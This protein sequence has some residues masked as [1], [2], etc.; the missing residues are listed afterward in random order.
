[1]S[2]RS[3]IAVLDGRDE[4]DTRSV[5]PRTDNSIL[6]LNSTQAAPSRP[7][8]FQQPYQLL[9]FSYTSLPS[10]QDAS[11]RI[12]SLEWNNSSMKYFISPPK[13]ANLAY[14]YERWI[15]RPEEKGR[16]DGLLEACLR[17]ECEGERRRAGVIAWRGV[18]TKILTAPYEDCD[19]WDLN[20]MCVDETL[21]LEEHLS[22]E[23]LREKSNLTGKHRLMT[24]YGY[25]FESYCTSDAPSRPR[26]TQPVNGW[27]GD[28]DTNVQWCSIVKTKLDSTR[29][30]IG[31]EV[32]C[33]RDK[34]T[35]RPDTFVELKTSIA[36]RP[37]NRNDEAKFEKK[38]LK[39][40]IQSFLLGV[41]EVVVGF[42]SPSGYLQTVQTFKT[43]DLPRSVRGKSGAWDPT[44]CLAWGARVFEFLRA[45][46]YDNDDE[47]GVWRATFT[48]G[49]GLS[50]RRLGVED[51]GDVRAGDEED[52]VGF[53][54]RWYW[55]RVHRQDD[56]SRSGDVGSEPNTEEPQILPKPEISKKN[57][58]TIHGWQI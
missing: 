34:N 16:L 9:S 43:M 21:Y 31:G 54:P 38:L 19:G 22:E 5:K 55:E 33:V 23:K 15:K 46:I 32:D 18:I 45:Q 20:V 49:V 42:R 37:G 53:M 40:Y 51:V 2:K 26:E 24:Y 14:G 7:P 6:L 17:S 10:P 36:I 8:P 35:G 13:S 41:P 52:R 39:F 56:T 4:S 3:I 25:S 48:P 58:A 29:M 11:Q 50:I 12:R 30:V 47:R 44:I 27:G 1:M 28:V 57:S